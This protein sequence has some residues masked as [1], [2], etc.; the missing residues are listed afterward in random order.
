MPTGQF[1]E[2]TGSLAS[3]SS[4]PQLSPL[5]SKPDSPKH[6]ERIS[7]HVS[8]HPRPRGAGSKFRKRD[9]CCGLAASYR[10]GGTPFLVFWNVSLISASVHKQVFD[11]R[12]PLWDDYPVQTASES[13]RQ[14]VLITYL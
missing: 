4:G 11:G 2:T 13:S 9:T 1:A 12:T 8:D 10:A 14:S 3:R 7:D 5:T 6:S